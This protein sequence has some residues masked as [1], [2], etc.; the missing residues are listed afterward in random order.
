MQAVVASLRRLVLQPEQ[1][2][3]APR[4]SRELS[5]LGQPP[6]SSD[7]QTDSG[8][9]GI[10][11]P[12]SVVALLNVAG[13]PAVKVLL[14]QAFLATLIHPLVLRGI[15]GISHILANEMQLQGPRPFMSTHLF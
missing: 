8:L 4:L 13:Q 5:E 3:Q 1:P 14:A 9:V 12:T 7:A 15:E 11:D 6:A 2:Q 10:D